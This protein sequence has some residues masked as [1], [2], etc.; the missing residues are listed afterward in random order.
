[1]AQA[2]E[3]AVPALEAPALSLEAAKLIDASAEK[4]DAELLGIFLEEA[5]EVL[6]GVGEHLERV[7]AQPTD[8]P[9]LTALRRAFHTLKGSGRMV[10]LTRV[11]EAAWAVEQTMNLWLQEERAATP[12]LLS[13]V[14]EAQQYFADNVARLKE[15]GVASDENA[16]VEFAEQV[17]RG[18]PLA[19]K[20]AP[21]EPSAPEVA[22]APPAAA[23]GPS[24][25]SGD[26]AWLLASS[27]LVLMMTI[28]GLGL[29]YGGMVRKKNVGDTVMTSFA[30]RGQDAQIRYLGHV[31]LGWLGES[32]LD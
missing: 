1:V 21:A 9:A 20:G 25:N 17:K 10:G 11:G 28:P 32:E 24:I 4:I 7:R 6:T 14:A 15:G 19:A 23:G 2:L 12:D 18:V 30:V 22:A 8:Q 26:N 16:L 31:G 3:A 27:A 13:L 29:F 5:E